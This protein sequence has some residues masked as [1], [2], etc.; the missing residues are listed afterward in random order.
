MAP[1][2]DL[3]A[4]IGTVSV[5]TQTY[6]EVQDGSCVLTLSAT[7]T[8]VFATA[9]TGNFVV[10]A[11]STSCDRSAKS[12]SS[13]LTVT[14][15]GTATGNG[16]V[17]FSVAANTQPQQRVGHITVGGSQ[18]FTVTQ[19]APFCTFS[20]QSRQRQ[21]CAGRRHRQFRRDYDVRLDGGGRR[22]LDRHHGERERNRQ[23]ND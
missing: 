21:L 11:S 13:W 4:R 22:P 1:N 3:N 23:R 14:S 12:D 15:G 10:T 6:T 16:T 9:S 19:A 7:S 8:Q 5:G 2:T 17:D 20:D 18:V